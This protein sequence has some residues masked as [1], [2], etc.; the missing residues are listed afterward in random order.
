MAGAAKAVCGSFVVAS[1]TAKDS[2]SLMPIR[3]CSHRNGFGA[4][5]LSSP[6]TWI[7]A[8]TTTPR[9][10]VASTTTARAVP[11]PNIFMN[12]S[13]IE[14]ETNV[15]VS[16]A[17]AALTI[18]PTRLRPTTIASLFDRPPSRASLIRLSRK[19]S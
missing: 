8:G 3:E 14:N 4:H 19:I 12:D 17:A 6:A 9:M 7:N 5:Q 10:I 2:A 16:R 1:S 13:P 11:I 18:R 15:I